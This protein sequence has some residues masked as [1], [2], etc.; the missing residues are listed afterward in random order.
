[1]LED[2]GYKIMEEEGGGGKIVSC[3]RHC[4]QRE[5]WASTPVL[6]MAS[7]RRYPP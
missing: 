5:Y 6:G 3:D 7:I 4:F 1:M 2:I